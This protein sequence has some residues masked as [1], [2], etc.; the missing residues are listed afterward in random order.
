MFMAHKTKTK[1][2]HL[3]PF[4][5]VGLQ[6]G[7]LGKVSTIEGCARR[8]TSRNTN[9]SKLERTYEEMVRNSTIH[10]Y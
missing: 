10:Y 2:S 7:C 9:R 3:H 1:L 4:L 6:V 8:L 5:R